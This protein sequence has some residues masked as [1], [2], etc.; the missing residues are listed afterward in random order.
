MPLFISTD[1]AVNRAIM[2]FF[3]RAIALA[4]HHNKDGLANLVKFSEQ[5]DMEVVPVIEVQGAV[6]THVTFY[7]KSF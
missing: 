4:T 1:P 6:R 3:S 2:I 5:L 7:T